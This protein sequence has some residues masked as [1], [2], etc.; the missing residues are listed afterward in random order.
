MFGKMARRRNVDVE[1]RQLRSRLCEN[2]KIM[3][4]KR[5]QEC[6]RGTWPFARQYC[7]G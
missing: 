3:E 1:R 4:S 6:E 5:G 2:K 7:S